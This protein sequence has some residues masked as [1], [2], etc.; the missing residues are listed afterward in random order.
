M[1]SAICFNLDQ[2]TILLSGNG[3]ITILVGWLAVLRF[4][5]T[6]TAKVMTILEKQSSLWQ[7]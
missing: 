2:S 4:N 5:A 3:F 1:S 7:H 6:L